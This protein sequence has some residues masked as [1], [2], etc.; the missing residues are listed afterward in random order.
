MDVPVAVFYPNAYLCLLTIFNEYVGS[1]PLLI[2]LS[3]ETDKDGIILGRGSVSKPVTHQLSVIEKKE[4]ISRHHGGLKYSNSNSNWEI[5]DLNS[6]NGIFVNGIR[7]KVRNSSND[8]NNSN[9]VLKRKC[10]PSHDTCILH[11]CVPMYLYYIYNICIYFCLY[12][13]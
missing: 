8:S 3:P 6:S 10:Q 4:V 12:R 5:Y 7:I 9:T 11:Y 13:W 1:A 2:P